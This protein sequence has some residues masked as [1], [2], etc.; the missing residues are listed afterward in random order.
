MPSVK[1]LLARTLGPISP[2]PLTQTALSLLGWAYRQRIF[3]KAARQAAC[4]PRLSFRRDDPTLKTGRKTAMNEP[5][6][7]GSAQAAVDVRNWV[8]LPQSCLL[9]GAPLQSLQTD[10]PVSK[11]GHR[12]RQPQASAIRLR[13]R[14]LPMTKQTCSGLDEVN[15]TRFAAAQHGTDGPEA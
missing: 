3:P 5:P 1:L 8:L 11:S 4:H 12:T 10:L 9:A 2:R 6:V 7:L 13:L 15:L 14:P